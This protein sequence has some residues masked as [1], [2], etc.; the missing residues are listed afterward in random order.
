MA[1][2]RRLRFGFAQLGPKPGGKVVLAKL[3]T[4]E[5]LPGSGWRKL[6][7][8]TWRT[9]EIEKDAGW[10]VRARDI[11]SIT[12]WRSFE[13][14]S[15]FCWIWVQA[16][17]LATAH[18]VGEAMATIPQ[19][20]LR[21]LH[22]EVKVTASEDVTLADALVAGPTWT[23]RRKTVG[24]M[25]ERARPFIS[26]GPPE[27]FCSCWHALD[28]RKDG[29]GTQSA[30]LLGSKLSGSSRHLARAACRSPVVG[31]NPD[32]ATS[33]FRS[34]VLADPLQPVAGTVRGRAE[35][36]V[37]TADEMARPSVP[38][39]VASPNLAPWQPSGVWSFQV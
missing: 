27:P 19:R 34:W 9:G 35:P 33:L 21:N 36:R 39:P 18:D 25:G 4:S 10:A 8:R 16:V 24:P 6:D 30:S 23:H 17:P 7:E 26:P 2:G 1:L 29:H 13:Q 20:M 38:R 15:D 22:A 37:I 12:A 28:S 31:R 3:L 14:K 32:H 5:E 11:G